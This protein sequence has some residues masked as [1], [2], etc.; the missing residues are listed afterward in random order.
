[1]SPLESLASQR[2]STYLRLIAGI[3]AIATITL[4][5]YSLSHT[6]SC[7]M[8]SFVIAYLLE[9]AVIFL[10]DRG[11]KRIRAIIL[12]Y[13][14]MGIATTFSLTFLLP[15][16]TIS[17]NAF[18]QNLPTQLLK[19]KQVLLGLQDRL[20]THYGSDEI[21]W[22]LDNI[23]SNADA[24]AHKA[25]AWGYHFATRFFF[26]LFNII[27]SPILVFFM[28]NY[29][30]KIRETIT[31]MLPVERKE[32][33]LL[34]GREINS[35]IGGYLKGQIMISLIVAVV[36]TPTLYFLDV[37]HPVVCGIFAGFASILPFIGVIIATMPALLLGWLQFGTG[38]IVVKIIAAFSVIYFFEGYL[39]KPLVFKESMNINPLLTIVM[40]MALGE[41]LGF[42]GILLALPITAALRIAY[43]HWLSGDF[44]PIEN[45]P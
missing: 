45:E 37:P 20:P 8:L 11:V 27:L 12:L 35:S 14:I 42:W 31:V 32:L 19:T 13:V 2:P 6:L 18:L 43:H 3:V 33:I 24:M 16:L 10:E 21:R 30:Q 29:K 5:G 39:I 38:A 26:N 9:P 28:L 22:L 1:M 44:S 4:V 23:T 41:M 40:V 25:G 15:Q 34:M 17:W 36:A 7:F